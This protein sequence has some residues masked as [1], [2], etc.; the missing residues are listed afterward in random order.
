LCPR[1]FPDFEGYRR[2]ILDDVVAHARSLGE[3]ADASV[4]SCHLWPELKER[5][6]IAICKFLTRSDA[7]RGALAPPQG[8]EEVQP[9]VPPERGRICAQLRRTKFLAVPTDD[10]DSGPNVL[11]PPWRISLALKE[12]RPPMFA[13]P[14]YLQDH[15]DL[16]RLLGVRDA[17]ELPQGE[18]GGMGESDTH[19]AAEESMRWLFEHGAESFSDVT[20]RCDGGQLFLHRNILMSRSDYFRAMFQGG[21]YCFREGQEGGADVN[22]VAPVAVARVLFG[23]LYHGRVDESP[24]EGPDGTSNAVELLALADELGVPRLFEFAQTWVANQQDLDDCADT[25]QLA[26]LH[27]AKVLET[28]TLALLAANLDVPEVEPQLER[29]SQ[30]HREALRELAGSRPRRQQP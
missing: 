26:A 21:D 29:L 28:A 20:V 19:R 2:P 17:L 14:A 23:Y 1:G 13:L 12:H 27:G 4:V 11:V 5:T 8:G 10:R 3:L 16:L 7:F 9:A 15:T 30:E 18:S 24:L 6:V 22:L 25:L